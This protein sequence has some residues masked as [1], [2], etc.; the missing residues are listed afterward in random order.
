MIEFDS[1]GALSWLDAASSD[2]LDGAQFGVVRM[3]VG[4]RVVSYNLYESQLAGLSKD[5]V[6]SRDFFADVAPCTNNYLIAERFRGEPE[7]DAVLDYVFTL[8]MKPT[9]VRLRL[10]R[11]AAAQHMYLLVRR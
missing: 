8:R 3:E 2:D 10:L 1:P 5:R 6:L 11:S 4:G 9:P 7:L